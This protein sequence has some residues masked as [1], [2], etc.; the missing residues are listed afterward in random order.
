[1]LRR[2]A[3]RADDAETVG[4]C[5]QI[6]GQEKAFAEVIAASWDRFAELSLRESGV[7][8]S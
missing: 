4:A 7:A 1:M 8:T 5:D 2:I 3:A 6:I